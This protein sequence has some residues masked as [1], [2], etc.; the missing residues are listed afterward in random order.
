M[1]VGNVAAVVVEG[2]HSHEVDGVS[3]HDQDVSVHEGIFEVVLDID[4]SV[5]SQKVVLVVLDVG[6]V[7]VDFV[8]DDGLVVTTGGYPCSGSSSPS[9]ILSQLELWGQSQIDIS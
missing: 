2:V 4:G 1:V 8:E 9:S 7:M 5:H 6:Y 3:L